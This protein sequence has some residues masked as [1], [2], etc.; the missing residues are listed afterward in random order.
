[1]VDLARRLALALVLTVLVAT[2]ARAE[3]DIVNKT[4]V[5]VELRA[6]GVLHVKEQIS[7]AGQ[8]RRTLLTRTRYDDANDRVYR[9][10]GFTGDGA[11]AGDV[12]TLRGNGTATIEY[13]VAGAVTQ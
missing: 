2:P 6:G 13:D 8:V 3:A 1:M 12:I 4:D 9:V 5:T 7:Y 11:L 10:T